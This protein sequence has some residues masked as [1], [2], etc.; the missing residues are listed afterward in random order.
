MA[1]PF[2]LA[3]YYFPNYHPDPRNA[4]VHGA[5]WT[6]WDILRH[7]RPRFPEH[8]QPRIPAWGYEDE[9]DPAVMG[10]KIDAAAD[11]GVD[12]FL[13]DWYWYEDGP[14]LA[15]GLEEGFLRAA[16]NRRLRFAV[17]WANHDWVALHPGSYHDSRQGLHS[18]LY[19]GIISLRGFEAAIDHVIGTYFPHPSYWRIDGA[20]YFSFYDLST[21]L[22]SFGGVEGTR[23]ALDMFRDKTRA[24]GFPGLH[25]NQVVWNLGMLPGETTIREPNA[26]LE[27]LGYDS[28]TSYVWIHHVPLQQ[29]PETDYRLVC[30]HYVRFWEKMDREI[31]IPYFPNVT[32]GWDSSPRTIQS[33]VFQNVG[34]PFTPIVAGNTPERFEEA[35][36]IVREKL[37]QRSRPRV[38][39]LNAWNEWTEGSYLEP[40]QRH[41]LA[42]LD[43]IRRVFRRS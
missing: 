3:A 32:M 12:V 13:F 28:C 14:F 7:A 31:R 35:L 6:E 25:L 1:N 34:Y 29:F 9:S 4:L 10:K 43:A 8:Y 40:D 24:A 41:G 19:P 42:Y 17:H 33:E 11:N 37:D 36:R 18:L 23:E 26:L 16:N 38:L 27:Q 5:G 2:T 39:T 15:R 21:L 30:G 20:P 22:K